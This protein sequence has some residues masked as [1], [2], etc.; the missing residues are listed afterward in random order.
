MKLLKTLPTKIDQA[1]KVLTIFETVILSALIQ[2][3]GINVGLLSLLV[4][5]DIKPLQCLRCFGFGHK[6]GYCKAKPSC[7]NCGGEH[8]GRQCREVKKCGSFC[9][10]GRETNEHRAI[11]QL[12]IIGKQL[13]TRKP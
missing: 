13:R 2:A 5:E 9:K 10:A 8:E 11:V 12:E 4:E 6:Q 1:I 7:Y 3:E